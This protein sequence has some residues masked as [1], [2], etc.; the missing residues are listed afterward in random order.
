MI[1]RFSKMRD[2]IF[3]KIILTVTALSFVSLFGVS[4]Y[5]NTANSNKAVIQVDNLELTQSQFA[6]LLQRDILR[7]KAAGNI[8]EHDDDSRNR[9]A[10]DK[11][12]STVH[13]AEEA[14]LFLDLHTA[15]RRFL[16]RDGAG[17]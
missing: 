5:I 16:V 14:C 2:S 11:F 4:G 6:Y 8:D 15:L 1:N 7:L 17:V 9:I 10:L 12:G 3:T 13:S